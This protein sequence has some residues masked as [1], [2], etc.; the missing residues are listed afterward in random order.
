MSQRN[1]SDPTPSPR[2][3]LFDRLQS[4]SSSSMPHPAML[5]REQSQVSS[6]GNKSRMD[7]IDQ[8][9]VVDDEDEELKAV[10]HGAMAES[11]D[12]AGV[13]GRNSN[14]HFSFVSVYLGIPIGTLSA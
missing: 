6:R 12:Q 8:E 7:S 13:T 5:E 2:L 3:G 11:T 4:S 9:A 10:F 1:N 14:K